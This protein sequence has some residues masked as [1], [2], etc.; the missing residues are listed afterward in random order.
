MDILMN[1]Q[2]QVIGLFYSDKRQ[3]SHLVT[4][5]GVGA[6]L[7]ILRLYEEPPVVLLSLPGPAVQ[8]LLLAINL[9]INLG[10][11]SANLSHLG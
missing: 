11:L 1:A 8:L 9:R 10:S 6:Q 3:H 7:W 4:P 5:V 2:T